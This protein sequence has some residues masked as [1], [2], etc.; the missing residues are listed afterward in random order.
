LRG[1][2]TCR[3]LQSHI[4]KAQQEGLLTKHARDTELEG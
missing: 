4:P 3:S 2:I 1:S